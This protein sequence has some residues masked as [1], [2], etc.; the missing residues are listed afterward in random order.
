MFRHVG[1]TK[2]WKPEYFSTTIKILKFGFKENNS[3][4]FLFR[5]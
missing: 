1:V 5:F 3:Y 2:L 4:S